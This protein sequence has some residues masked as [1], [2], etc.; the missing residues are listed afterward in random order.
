MINLKANVWI[1]GFNDIGD[2]DSNNILGKIVYSGKVSDI[3]EELAKRYV[4][5][6]EWKYL[7]YSSTL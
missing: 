6:H 7:E 5:R 1:A 2:L 4:D 3:T